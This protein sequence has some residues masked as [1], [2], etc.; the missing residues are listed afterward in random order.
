MNKILL[1][2]MYL[3]VDYDVFAATFQVGPQRIYTFPS[4]VVNLVQPGDTIDIDPGVYLGDVA[5]WTTDD[6]L[7]RGIGGKAHLRAN[8]ANAQG[9]AI[10][11]I[12]ANN[13]T[14]ENIEFSEA[15]VPDHN[16]AGIRM[17][18]TDLTVRHCYFHDNEV[19]IL[20]GDNPESSINIE[21]SEFA[22]NG[23]GDGL[24]HHIYVN[25]IFRLTVRFSYLHH[26]NIGHHI[27]SRARY[28]NIMYNRITDEANGNSS[29]LIDLANGGIAHVFGNVMM[30]G[31]NAEN[32][33][34]IAFALEG[35]PFEYM[36]RLFVYNNSMLNERSTGSFIHLIGA[37]MGI[38]FNNIFAGTGT[39][40]EEGSMELQANLN[41][42]NIA[43]A[44][45]LDAANFNYDLAA[46]SEA[47]DAGINL[48]GTGAN[49]IPEH[50]YK[51]PADST[52]RPFDINMDIGAYEFPISTSTSMLDNQE[53]NIQ[54][55]PNPIIGEAYIQI[56][57]FSTAS[58]SLKFQIYQSDGKLVK[59]SNWLFLSAQIPIPSHDLS[60]GLYHLILL[61][62]NRRIIG[63]TSFVTK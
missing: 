30:Q 50:Q 39:V 29:Y 34:M 6:L 10:W 58:K 61:D 54:V 28:T 23:Y 32:K 25:F 27:K 19:G 41:V 49:F 43:E 17:E 51:H 37:P 18:G 7:I 22:D 24:S 21:F 14:I 55:V 11:V 59:E 45:F 47:R 56:P 63:R 4:Q 26:A 57:S 62:K 60:S 52:A 2:I 1:L 5:V 33:T 42:E 16:G 35:Y 15:T 36:H 31:P 46:S 44:G 8:G 13:L 3:L 53:L 48:F 40:I 20:A 12:T 38:V 9:K